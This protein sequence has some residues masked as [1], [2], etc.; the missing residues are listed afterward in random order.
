MSA[1]QSEVAAAHLTP[2]T[3]EKTMQP[4]SVSEDEDEL[5]GVWQHLAT[6][7][8]DPVERE[9]W[10]SHDYHTSLSLVD[11]EWTGETEAWETN[12]QTRQRITALTPMS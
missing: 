6:S 12:P 3:V 11:C 2:T 4:F 10:E 5:E 7:R 9:F 1:C 8:Y